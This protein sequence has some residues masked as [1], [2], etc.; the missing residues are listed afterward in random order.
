MPRRSRCGTGGYFFH[1][2]NR[3]I[4]GLTLFETSADYY[5]FLRVL[6]EAVEGFPNIRLCGYALMPTHW[7]LV[8]WPNDDTCLSRCMHWLT[9]THARRWRETRGNAGRGAV[10][11]SRFKAVPVQGEH[12]LRVMRYVERNPVAARCV[13]RVEDW[14]WTSATLSALEEARPLLTAW[15][16][17]KPADWLETLNV[18][19]P[20]KDVDEIRRA[21]RAGMP[22]GDA[23]WQTATLA[24]L[25]RIVA[26]GRRGR[27]HKQQKPGSVTFP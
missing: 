23:E 13:A 11:Q 16:V 6:Q 8:L 1:V 18:P 12:F 4:Q 24:A 26:G 27:P 9:T 7:H 22:L 10:Y 19:A 17:P 14:P 21:I 20:T 25:H 3:V 2:F 5:A 15:P